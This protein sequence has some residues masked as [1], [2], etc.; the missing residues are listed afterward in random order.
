VNT[1]VVIDVRGLGKRYVR[2]PQRPGGMLG[3]L[4]SLCGRRA[5]RRE[6]GESFWAFRDAT[7][8]VHRGER[9]GII[10]RNGAG[11][12]TL[13]KVLSRIVDPTC[14]EARVRGRLTSLLELGTGFN[15]ALTGR[16]NVQLNAALHG[17]GR[18]EV[19]A[20]LDEIARFSG[21][22]EALDAPVKQYSSGMVVRLAFSI[23]ASLDPDVLLLDEVLAV[24]D[25][26]FQRKCMER[27]DALGRDG[28][29][30]L[31]VSHGLD[32]VTRFCD[33]G[34]WLEEGR[35][36]GDGPVDEVVDSYIRSVVDH[37]LTQREPAPVTGLHAPAAALE[38]TGGR[39]PRVS[40]A[41]PRRGAP[42]EDLPEVPRA[43]VSVVLGTFDRQTF[44]RKAI[45]SV[46]AN[47][48]RVPF[49]IIVVDGGSTDGSLDWLLRQK[50]VIT[51]V[52]HNRG[53]FRGKPIARRSWGYFMNLAFKAAQGRYVLM[54]SD[55]CLLLPGAVNHGLT[56]FER[57]ES[58]GRR[59]AGV[60]FYF[61]N[62]PDE[63]TYY[64]QRTLGGR[65]FVN[66]G[67]YLRSAMEE[68]GWVD[69]ERYRF[70]K[71]DGDLCL[72][73]WHAGY[74]VVDCPEAF[75]EHYA[76][77]NDTVRAANSA[78][79]DHDRAAYVERWT[80]IYYDP[81]GPELRSRITR[82]FDDPARTAERF[83]GEEIAGD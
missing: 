70:Y 52:Q 30:I 57:L 5:P 22:G 59:V 73:M 6:A 11:K 8:T 43:V 53:E 24:G 20:R 25:L 15:P 69:E 18:R 66:H 58:E 51:I 74:E 4:A 46:R 16:E 34:L 65:L 54:L 63:R 56:T 44:L 40:L 31:L 61:R 41:R 62:W 38:P 39:A 12:S 50:D 78:V 49:E 3:V 77:A 55:D 35:I 42:R 72:K 64:V 32:A 79:L 75:V 71:A 68:V 48:I 9:L 1:E 2:G 14:G 67:M 10:G 82:V 33:R 80:G 36:V 23:V 60:A 27:L 28:C 83:H 19:E 29:T 76:H 26:A 45:E 81:D 7:F 47:G 37:S 17:F 13:L 21:I